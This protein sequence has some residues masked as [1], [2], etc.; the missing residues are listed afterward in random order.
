MP[1]FETEMPSSQGM[2][3]LRENKIRSGNRD[4]TR[5]SHVL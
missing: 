3:I 1:H 5:V 4:H 2:D